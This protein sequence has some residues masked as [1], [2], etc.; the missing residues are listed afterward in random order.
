MENGT[1]EKLWTQSQVKKSK[2]VAIPYKIIISDGN[3]LKYRVQYV[4][5]GNVD[6]I[7]CLGQDYQYC[8][9]ILLNYMG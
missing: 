3:I 2:K 7:N 9:P 4:D 6:L 5:F 8:H 1:E